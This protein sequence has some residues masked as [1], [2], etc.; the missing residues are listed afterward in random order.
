M[1]EVPG[2]LGFYWVCKLFEEIPMWSFGYLGSLMYTND[3]QIGDAKKKH[4][5]AIPY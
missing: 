2:I 5:P 4:I 1:Y 3:W